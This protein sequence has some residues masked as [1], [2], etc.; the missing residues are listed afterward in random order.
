MKSIL[1]VFTVISS[2]GLVGCGSSSSGLSDIASLPKATASVSATSSILVKPVATTGTLVKDLNTIT[3]TGNSRGLCEAGSIVKDALRET[4]T[5]DKILCYIGVMERNNL[6]NA[7]YDGTDKYYTLAP[8]ADE[9]DPQTMRIKFNITESGGQISNFKMWTCENGSTQSQYLS[10]VNADGE[11]DMVAVSRFS[12]SSGGNTF[13]NGNRATVEGT[14]SS[15]GAWTSKTLTSRYEGSSTYEG[16]TFTNDGYAQIIQ[17][18]T[19]LTLSAFQMGT[20][21]D[22]SAHTFSSEVFGAM[23]ILGAGSLSTFALGDGSLKFVVDYGGTSDSGTTSWTGDDQNVLGDVTSGTFYSTANGGTVPTAAAQTITFD[24][25]A[26]E[27]WDC[28]APSGATFTDI[29]S[30]SFTATVEAGIAT[31]DEQFAGDDN[32]EYIECHQGD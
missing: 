8:A 20:Y 17:A 14:V 10:L 5:G 2:I 23:E 4:G 12:S 27:D 22:G 6:F 18:A 13:S 9:E 28:T 31:C 15:T 1:S 32:R 30:S 29:A 16:N 26:S 7:S 25:S 21:N 19:S 11:V 24:S 3:W